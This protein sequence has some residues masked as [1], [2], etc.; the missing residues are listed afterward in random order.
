MGCAPPS[1]IRASR[2]NYGST[3]CQSATALAVG[4]NSRSARRAEDRDSFGLP[5]ETCTFDPRKRGNIKS[6]RASTL[7]NC[8]RS[9]HRAGESPGQE[10]GLASQSFDP[11][12]A[13]EL[14][15]AARVDLTLE[16]SIRASRGNYMVLESFGP[17]VFLQ[18]AQARLHPLFVPTGRL[19][20]LSI[21]A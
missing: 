19:D 21:R 3:R 16:P 20:V 13:R 4:P 17:G 14:R 8:L 9:A 18:S 15:R 12:I 11:R 2:G 1:L 10:I 6:R 5:A 7:P